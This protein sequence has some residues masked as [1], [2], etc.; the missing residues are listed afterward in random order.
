MQGYQITR[1]TQQNLEHSDQ[2]S[3][4]GQQDVLTVAHQNL[5]PGYPPGDQHVDAEE[6]DKREAQLIKA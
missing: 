2:W 5:N 3:S 4:Q 1:L 6:S